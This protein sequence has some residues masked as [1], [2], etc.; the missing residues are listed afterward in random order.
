MVDVV[1]PD[2]EYLANS[3]NNLLSDNPD[4]TDGPVVFLRTRTKVDTMPLKKDVVISPDQMLFLPIIT[5]AINEIDDP[6]MND[7]PKRRSEANRDIDRGDNPPIAENVTIDGKPIVKNLKD[8]RIESPEFNLEVHRKCELEEVTYPKG[9][10]NLPTVAAGYCLLLKSLPKRIEPY[11]IR[12]KAKGAGT[13]QTEAIY[14]VRVK[15]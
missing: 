3:W 15:D 14:T 4:R 13:Y 7:E 5:S 10:S 8:F 2:G 6:N 11:E 9:K 12:V 1:K